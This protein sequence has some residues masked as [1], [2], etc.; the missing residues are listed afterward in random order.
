MSGWSYLNTTFLA[1]VA[2]LT[3]LLVDPLIKTFYL[4]RVF[5]G[6]ARH[7]GAERRPGMAGRR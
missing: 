2:V 7:T 1:L 6:Q 3:H 4:L 5:H